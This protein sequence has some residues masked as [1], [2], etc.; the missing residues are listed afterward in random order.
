VIQRVKSRKLAQKV[1]LTE[2]NEWK[3]EGRS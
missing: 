1:S 3:A 2:I